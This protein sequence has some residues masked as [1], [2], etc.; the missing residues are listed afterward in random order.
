MY[1]THL[2]VV[3][4]VLDESNRVNQNLFSFKRILF[5]QNLYPKRFYVLSQNTVKP[6]LSLHL[7]Y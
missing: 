4:F 5:K 7:N 6:T 1:R 3:L 2:F